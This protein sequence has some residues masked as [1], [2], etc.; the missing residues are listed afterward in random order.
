V[1]RMLSTTIYEVKGF[2]LSVPFVSI[3][4]DGVFLETR[5]AEQGGREQRAF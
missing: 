2:G 5:A 4:S 3:L 1:P